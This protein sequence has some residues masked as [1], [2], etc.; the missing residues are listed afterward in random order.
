[1]VVEHDAGAEGPKGPWPLEH[2]A[3]EPGGAVALAA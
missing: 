2:A 3:L 1:M